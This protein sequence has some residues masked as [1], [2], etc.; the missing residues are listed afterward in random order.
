[1]RKQLY[2]LTFVSMTAIGSDQVNKLGPI[3]K[4]LHKVFMDK[5]TKN[6]E[7]A[8]ALDNQ[9]AGHNNSDEVEKLKREFKKLKAEYRALNTKAEEF[10]N[11]AE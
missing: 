2:L 7:L 4:S 10:L 5:L 9:A 1:M 6:I 8:K 3:A 11:S